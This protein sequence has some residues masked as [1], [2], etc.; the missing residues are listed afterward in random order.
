MRLKQLSETLATGS[1][2]YSYDGGN[3]VKPEHEW[4][5]QEKNAASRKIAGSSAPGTFA[6]VN[7]DAATLGA[8][9][10]Y[11]KAQKIPNPVDLDTLH[12][13]LLYSK[14]NLPNYTPEEKYGEP[15]V[16][17]AAGLDIFS[18]SGGEKNCLVLKLDCEALKQRHSDLMIDHNADYD[19]DEYRPH[20]TLSYDV[21]DA[22][23]EDFEDFDRPIN[24][25]GEYHEDLNK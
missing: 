10:S 2:S 19:F 3:T 15:L 23:P 25:T 9:S 8:F 16:A 6:G 22:K 14:R 5:E 12:T 1:S 7:F 4:L 20:V 18:G 11:M 21:G 24:I 13:T 17:K